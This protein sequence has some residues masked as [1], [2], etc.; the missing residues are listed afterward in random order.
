MELEILQNRIDSTNYWD[1]KVLN[2]SIKYFGDEVELVIDSGEQAENG[3]LT[4]YAIKFL[5]CYKA[6]YKTDARDEIW[7][8]GLDVKSMSE[9]QLGHY[10]Q[11]ITVQKGLERDFVE[12]YLN[13]SLL[14]VTITCKDVSTI[15]EKYVRDNFFWERNTAK[16][17]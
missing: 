7:R 10:A 5:L 12:V 14:F 3:L 15:K 2:F 9:N 4:C 17:R 16:D 6:E 11:E 13:T 1:C 8:K